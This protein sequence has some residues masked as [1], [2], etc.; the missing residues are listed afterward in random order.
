MPV[1]NKNK[2][3]ITI[4][5]GKDLL[6]KNINDF[7]LD[8]IFDCG[9]AFR[10]NKIN[11]NTWQGV[12]FSKVLKVAQNGKSI[13]FYDTTEN[14]FETI[15][16]DYFDLGTNYTEYKKVLCAD[17][18]MRKG[19]NY[20]PGIR[21]LKQDKWETLCS[22]IISQ[23]NN[24]PRIKSII[25]KFCMLFGKRIHCFDDIEYFDFPT[26]SIVANLTEEDLAPIKA[27]FRAKYIIDCAKKVVSGQVDFDFI[28][29]SN[30]EIAREHLKQIVG[31]GTKVADCTLLFGFGKI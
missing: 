29:K 9:Q 13:L 28:D 17:T 31:V 12:A 18:V 2:K 15:W 19:I 6:I 26:P 3:L 11:N 24:I 8:N 7:N 30:K 25:D 23:N 20:S 10:F 27:G 14:E 22:F 21:I 4:P 16:V 5:R 1:P